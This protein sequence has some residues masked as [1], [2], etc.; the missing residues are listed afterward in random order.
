MPFYNARSDWSNFVVSWTREPREDFGAF[1]R[2]YTMAAERLSETLLQQR[3]SDYEAYPVAFLFRHAFELS[4]KHTIYRAVELAAYRY[5]ADIDD[6]LHNTHDLMKL[7]A[8][9]ATVLTTVC[10]ED[11]FVEELISR[12]N[13]TARE[14]SA[15]DPESFSYRY[16]IKRDGSRSAQPHQVVNLRSLAEHVSPLLDDLDTLQFGMGAEIDMAQDGLSEAYRQSEA[17]F[18][19]LKD[20]LDK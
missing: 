13:T 1:C 7:A 19:R 10:P 17:L 15:L 11:E 4:L 9:L 6:R 20:D 16:P 3:F 12:T 5:V 8:A 2:G 14:W 18:E